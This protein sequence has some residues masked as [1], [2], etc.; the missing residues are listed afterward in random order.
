MQEQ[1]KFEIASKSS[2]IIPSTYQSADCSYAGCVQ[3]GME[4]HL[5]P[6]FDSK[7]EAELELRCLENRLSYSLIV[8]SQEIGTSYER[9][10]ELERR[11]QKSGR[12]NCIYTGL[13]FED[14]K[15]S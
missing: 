10:E 1:A 2:S 11:Y 9:A 8:T 4:T 13:M 12:T 14:D 3:L 6:W 7:E 15:D 5:T